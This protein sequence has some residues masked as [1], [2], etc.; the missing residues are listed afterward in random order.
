M[1]PQNEFTNYVRLLLY[2]TGNVTPS[3]EGILLTRGSIVMFVQQDYSQGYCVATVYRHTAPVH[4]SSR[5]LGWIIRMRQAAGTTLDSTWFPASDRRLRV[6]FNFQLSQ[7]QVPFNQI[8]NLNRT[9]RI[10]LDYYFGENF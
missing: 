9:A 3:L 8:A 1:L 2:A 10:K 6:G 7:H 5:N 4:L